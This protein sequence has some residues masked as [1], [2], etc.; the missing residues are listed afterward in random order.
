MVGLGSFV[1]VGH[2]CV[3]VRVWTGGGVG[4]PLGRSRP[5]SGVFLLTVPGRC[6]FC[7]SFVLFMSCS[8]VTVLSCA[9]G[10]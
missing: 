5:S 2:L 8:V 7:G 3:L 4:A 10:C 1:R 6:F 9:S